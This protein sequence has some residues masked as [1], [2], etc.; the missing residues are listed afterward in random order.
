MNKPPKTLKNILKKHILMI[1][2]IPTAIFTIIT[3]VLILNYVNHQ[4]ET[5]QMMTLNII[6]GEI[7]KMMY[8][9]LF[10]LNE[11]DATYH[12]NMLNSEN[13][14]EYLDSI[15]NRYDLFYSIRIVNQDGYVIHAPESE[16]DIV[17]FNV[18]YQDYY[19]SALNSNESYWSKV[20]MSA[21]SSEATIA[22]S[23]KGQN[24]EVIIGYCSLR[25][26]Q[27]LVD[28]IV[29]D[30]IQDIAVV[31]GH[32]TFI[33]HSNFSKVLERDNEKYYNQVKENGTYILDY[34]NI[35]YFVSSRN[36][37]QADFTIITYKPFFKSYAIVWNLIFVC[38]LCVVLVFVLSIYIANIQGEPIVVAIS[39]LIGQTGEISQGNY[40]TSL[41]HS[42]ILEVNELKSNFN[43]MATTLH[44]M[45]NRLSESQMELEILNDD[46]CVQNEEIKR[47]E[48]HITQIINSTYDGILVLDEKF[49]VLWI[50]NAVF[51][52][53]DV[54]KKAI[55]KNT[56]CYDL[57][58]DFH[59]KCYHCDMEVVKLSHER[60]TKVI[61]H[62]NKLIEETYIPSFD[63]SGHFTGIIK[64]FRDITDKIA[65]ETKLNRA[66]KME[67]IGRL[68]GGIAHDFNNILQVIIGYS[69]LLMVQMQQHNHSES[70]HTK[71]KTI[72]EAATKA[73]Q[74]IKKLMTFSKLDQ[75]SPENMSLNVVVRDLGSMLSRIIGDDIILSF[76]L[77]DYLPD[78]YADPTQ[79]EQIIM[80]LCINAKHAMPNGG[81]ID[82]HTYSTEKNNITYAV[83]EITDNGTG[84]PNS[85]KEKIYDPF[86]TTKEIGKGTGLGLAIVLGIVEKH[87]GFIE[88]DSQEG[89]G[90]TFSVYIPSSDMQTLIQTRP[91]VIYDD[92][93][94]N[95]LNVIL[96]EDD[97]SVRSFAASV[98]RSKGVA[99]IEAVDGR[100]AIKQ[101]MKVDGKVD[102]LILDVI[103]PGINGTEVYDRIKNLNPKIKVIFT[104]GYSNDF[105]GEDYNLSLKEKVLQKPYKNEE[106]I[107]TILEVME[108]KS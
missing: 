36:L 67:A 54:E 8:S 94:L 53:F 106:L 78:V 46:L 108:A 83:L 107:I 50:N 51:E 64:T 102:L 12:S 33:A 66:I 19:V 42:P 87:H 40:D 105:L 97:E 35:K 9:N 59:S 29:A 91:T 79:I 18:S 4:E 31:E 72:Y 55:T 20:F 86:F 25:D 92:S 68:T 95:G 43:S 84:I 47:S 103:M 13:V 39:E 71:M 17:G 73:E 10:V 48:E 88:L 99:L 82:I 23:L 80:N 49:N 90:T 15:I 5:E 62:N 74:L 77:E 60:L 89:V 75:I 63:D 11:V 32:G 61:S 3:I 34:N 37:P 28:E 1:T 104:S 16:K 24:D 85:I 98:L 14:N 58:F 2:V 93:K 26:L 96:A 100:D 57:I 81:N 38:L 56:K 22:M 45:F 21:E 65:L 7:Q 69:D 101:Y 27:K 44:E 70:M 41:G 6:E 52:L 76:R 30:T